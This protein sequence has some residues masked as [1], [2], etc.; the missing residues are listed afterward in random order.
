MPTLEDIKCLD[1]SNKALMLFTSNMQQNSYGTKEYGSFDTCLSSEVLDLILSK[2]PKF[3]LIDSY[4]IGNHGEEHISFDKRCE[5]HDCFVIENV[6]LKKEDVNFIKSLD[7]T[8]D[9]EAKSTGKPCNITARFS[10]KK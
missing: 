6:I 8:F 9:K 2:K 3:I 5:A 1:I 10:H 4:G 7:I